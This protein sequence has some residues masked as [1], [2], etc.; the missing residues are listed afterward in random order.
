MRN[1]LGASSIP[2]RGRWL[3]F[4]FALKGRVKRNSIFCGSVSEREMST[5]RQCPVG[6]QSI[7]TNQLDQLTQTLYLPPSNLCQHFLAPLPDRDVGNG[8]LPLPFWTLA[9]VGPMLLAMAM[10]LASWSGFLPCPPL[11]AVTWWPSSLRNLPLMMPTEPLRF[12]VACS[13]G[14]SRI[15]P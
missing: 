14:R 15:D 9:P 13:R 11:H 1:S 8:F 6:V 2:S 3:A 7:T 4:G 12:G 10:R 5:I